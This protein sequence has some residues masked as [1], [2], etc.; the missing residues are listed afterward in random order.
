MTDSPNHTIDALRYA[1]AALPREMVVGVSTAFPAR[2][3]GKS[4]WIAEL[5]RAHLARGGEALLQ[6]GDET[7]R[8]T[9]V[10]LP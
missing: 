8:S 9:G 7:V 1:M 2:Q 4:R 5:V 6:S 3:S 10:D